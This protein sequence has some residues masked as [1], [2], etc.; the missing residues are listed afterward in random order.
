M[1]ED[2]PADEV[3]I[4]VAERNAIDMIVKGM[5]PMLAL[6]K[7]GL[8]YKSRSSEYRRLTR[9]AGRLIAEKANKRFLH[10]VFYS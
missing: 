10:L 5:K 6:R 9:K 4:E 3:P 8:E 2:G 1:E 7:T